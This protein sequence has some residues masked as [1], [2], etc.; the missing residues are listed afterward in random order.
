MNS[1]KDRK[2]LFTNANGTKIVSS[3]IM[4]ELRKR[5]KESFNI[6][7]FSSMATA[8][9]GVQKLLERGMTSAEI[10]MITGFTIQKI[11]DVAQYMLMAQDIEKVIN[12][13]L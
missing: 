11:D 12:E 7:G 10:K 2:L 13:K 9:T 5:A 8:L 6:A 4:D 1:K 3:R